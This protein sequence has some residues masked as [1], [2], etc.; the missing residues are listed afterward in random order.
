[1]DWTKF[2]FAVCITILLLDH[3][4]TFSQQSPSN[5][6]PGV[7]FGSLLASVGIGYTDGRLNMDRLYAICLPTP[8][9]PGESVYT[10]NPDG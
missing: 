3:R 8:E 9:K 4:M 2:L 5:C 6:K 7:T 10:Y 1:M